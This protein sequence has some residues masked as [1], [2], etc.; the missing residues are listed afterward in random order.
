MSTVDF[1]WGSRE[2]D[3]SRLKSPNKISDLSL[4]GGPHSGWFRA[5][6]ELSRGGWPVEQATEEVS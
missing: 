3:A 6:E 5:G 2:V 4:A 1:N